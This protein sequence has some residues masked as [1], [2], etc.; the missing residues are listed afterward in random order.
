MIMQD[1]FDNK[2]KYEQQQGVIYLVKIFEL[3]FRWKMSMFF[4][5]FGKL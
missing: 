2:G 3:M 5:L 4:A 1:S